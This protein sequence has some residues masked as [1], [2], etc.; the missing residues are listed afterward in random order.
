MSIL[1]HLGLALVALIANGFSALAGGGAGLLQLP[2]LIFLGLPYPVAL[3][4]HKIATVALGAG[5]G[6]RHVKE[7]TFSPARLGVILG[8]GVP[9]VLLGAWLVLEI[10][11]RAG[12]IALGLLT[13]T[14]GWYS[15]RR[16]QL[17]QTRRITSDSLNH[18]LIGAA[19]L[20][21]I[22]ILNGSLASGTGLMVTLWLVRWY[23][24]SYTEAVGYTMV[25]VGLVWNGAGALMLGTFGTVQWDWLPALLLGSFIGGYLGATLAIRY[26]NRLVK[27][28]F[29]VVTVLTG[30]ALLLPVP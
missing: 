24:M 7:S 19:G 11:P 27:R 22:G 28:A 3:A 1:E 6:L 12:E 5:A 21:V 9:G 2:A 18:A 26:G 25:L 16:P 4:T 15:W 30:I 17:G 8:A 20:F 23:G 14:L 10:P 29:E 13:V